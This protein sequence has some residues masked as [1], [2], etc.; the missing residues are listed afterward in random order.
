MRYRWAVLGAGTLAQACAATFGIGLP[1]LVPAL[2]EQ[3]ALTISEV[4]LVLAA[5]WVGGT[6]TLLL[7]GLA[8][9]RFGERRV[10]GVGLAGSAAFLGGAAFAPGLVALLGLLTLAGAAGSSVQSASGRAVMQWFAASERGLA[11]GIRQTAIPLGGLVAALVLPGLGVRAAFLLLASLSLAGALAG[12]LVLREG[13]AVDVLEAHSVGATLRNGR[14]WRLCFGSGIYLYAQVAIIGFGVL[15]LHDAHGL[16]VRSA[17]LVLAAAQVLAV[18]L[19]IGAGRWSDVVGSRI[20]P[21]RRVGVAVAVATA[22]TALLARGPIGLLVPVVVLAGG[23]SMAWN[24]LSYTAAA[25]LAGPA[26]SGAAIGFQQ[27]VL[28]AVGIVAPVLFAASVSSGS[29]TLAFA[30][31]AVVPLVGW[32]GLRSLQGY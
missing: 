5:P 15:F 8:A 28:S 21:L 11:L 10:L 1:V 3:Y 13:A 27:T 26:R 4:G 32:R 12:V 2:R 23:L 9:D 16:S 30:I 19:R 24:G 31:A 18:A 22:A 20:G 6:A 14:L 29:W 7:W 17:A 25:E